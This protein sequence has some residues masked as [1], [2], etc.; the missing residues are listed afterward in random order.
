[1]RPI[2]V[3]EVMT[4]AIIGAASEDTVADA[5]V[6][7][8][9]LG[10]GAVVIAEKGGRMAGILTARDI[11]VRVVAEK[12]DPSRV[13]VSDVMTP[14]MVSIN[15]DNDIDEALDLMEERQIRRLLVSDSDGRPSG[16][17][18]L[19]DLALTVQGQGPKA[20]FAED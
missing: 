15:E 4:R 6:R 16:V 1:M 19:S 20:R 2:L 14:G 11:V 13:K 8:K 9:D 3:K 10:V 12:L 7:M 5:A 18:S 17:V